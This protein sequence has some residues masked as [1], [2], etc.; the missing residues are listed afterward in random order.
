MTRL[1]R[2]ARGNR[3]WGHGGKGPSYT[4]NRIII[5]RRQT[6]FLQDQGDHTHVDLGISS[7]ARSTR[8]GMGPYL[9]IGRVH[10]RGINARDI[11]RWTHFTSQSIIYRTINSTSS[12]SPHPSFVIA[13]DDITF[14]VRIYWLEF[15]LFQGIVHGTSTYTCR[16]EGH[17]WWLSWTI[18][19]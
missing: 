5:G 16:N 6:F 3:L 14:F 11:Q 7:L 1:A 15:S 10:S 13:L 18:H 8:T 2:A 12:L 17:A 4:W 19:I 9:F